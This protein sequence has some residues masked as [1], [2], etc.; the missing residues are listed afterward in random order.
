MKLRATFSYHGTTV[1]IHAADCARASDTKPS[2]RSVWDLAATEIPA[3]KDE[4][5]DPAGENLKARGWKIEVCPCAKPAGPVGVDGDECG[6][7]A[8][9]G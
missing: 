2:K 7:R 9:H 1:K 4:L 6:E 3:A 5:N 8:S